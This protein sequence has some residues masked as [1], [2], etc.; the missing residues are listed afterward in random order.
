MEIFVMLTHLNGVSAGT[1]EHIQL[2]LASNY[3]IKKS[4]YKDG[5]KSD[6]FGVSYDTKDRLDVFL[7]DRLAEFSRYNELKSNLTQAEL[8]KLFHYDYHNCKDKNVLLSSSQFIQYRYDLY[9][10]QE[11]IEVFYEYDDLVYFLKKNARLNLLVE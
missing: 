4:K 3:K 8:S 9:D 2:V 7:S 1:Y 5:F 10:E 6:Y 11:I